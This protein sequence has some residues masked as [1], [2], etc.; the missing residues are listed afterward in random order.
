VYR[1]VRRTNVFG[2]VDELV[3]GMRLD[4][5]HELTIAVQLDHNMLSSVADAGAVPDPIDEALARVA[6][7][8]SDPVSR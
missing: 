8:S 7:T 2:D 1:A 6:E 3:I 5:G 4:S